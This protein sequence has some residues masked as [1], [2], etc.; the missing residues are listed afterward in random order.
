[1]AVH[2]G[3]ELR[4][5]LVVSGI[6][7]TRFAKRI[8]TSAKTVHALFK[9]PSMDTMLLKK[10]SEVL[11]FDFFRLYSDELRP[12]LRDG[13]AVSEPAARYGKRAAMDE[14]EIIIRP[15]QNQELLQSLIKAMEKKDKGR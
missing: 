4:K 3:T 13:E 15:G 10:C 1:M 7:V 11:N 12:K 5:R 14:L 2:I 8:G 6:P 9:R